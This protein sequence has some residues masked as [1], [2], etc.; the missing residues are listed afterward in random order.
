ML[1]E[2]QLV[3]GDFA[4]HA[5]QSPAGTVDADDPTSTSDLMLSGMRARVIAFLCKQLHAL[6]SALDYTDSELG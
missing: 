2:L 5:G 3:I 1:R 4:G 6:T